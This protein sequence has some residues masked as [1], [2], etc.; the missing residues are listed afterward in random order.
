MNQQLTVQKRSGAKENIDLDKI[1]RVIEWAA[2][3]LDNVSVS[4]VELRSHIQFYDGIKTEDIHETIIK[5]AADLISEQ[6]PDYQYLSA[7]LAIFHLRKKAYGQFEPPK[8]VEHIRKMV[9]MGKYDKHILEDYTEEELNILDGYIDHWRDMNFS[10]AAVKQLEGKYLVQNRVTGEIYESAQFLYIMVAACLF[11]NYP[12]ETRLAYIR[13]FYDAVSQFKISLPT[14]IMSGVRTPTRQ[15]SSCVLIECDD[16]L[17]SINATASAIVR[18][19]SQRAGIGINAGRIRALGSPIR[20]GEAFHT[21]CIPFYKYFQT[22]VKCCSQG[23]VRGGAATLFYPMW[24]REVENLLVLKNNRGV[25]ENR[26]R[27]MDYGVQIN[28]LMYTRL[29]KGGNISLFS[30]SDV[31]G[32]YDSFFADQEEFERLYVQYEQDASIQRETVK[33]VELF[34]LMMQERASTGRIYI[35]NVDHCNTHSPFDPKVAPIRQS[36]LCLEI[37][38]PTKPLTNVEDDNGEIALCTLSAFNLGAI[39]E[40][41]ELE[42]LADLTIRALDS[43]L[44]YQDYPLPAARKA[45]MNRR[46]LGVGVINF[47]YYLAKNGVRYSDGSANG[48]THRTFEAI[49]YYLLKASLGLA[50]EKGACPSF[51][52]TTYSQGVLPIDTYKRDLDKVCEEPLHYDWETLRGEIVEHGLRNSTLSALMPS[53]TSSQISNATNGIEPPRGFVSVKASKDGILKQVVPEYDKYKENY[54]LLWNIGSNDGYLQLVGIMQKFV[55]QAISANTN[56]DPSKQAGGKTPM[57]LLLKDLLSAY[58]L[59][60]KTLYYHNTRDGADDAQQDLA[61]QDDDCAGGACKI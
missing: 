2:K 5:A 4:Q 60:V 9:D 16:S 41:D 23:G 39:K 25:E 7:R 55:D 59:G 3:D 26:V 18:Y 51:N 40:L 42:D 21:G 10:Y 35:Q 36:N 58:K 28:K 15:F 20:G 46:T 29:I 11:A 49:Q 30:P 27:H 57:K 24:H 38:L 13:R 34:S 31:P 33:A 54:E 47:A 22:A 52:E 50:K 6:T 17:D 37:A 19:V 12:K 61:V 1:H 44:D 14:P 53:E 48:L 56:Y 32:L 45:T 43:L 8:L